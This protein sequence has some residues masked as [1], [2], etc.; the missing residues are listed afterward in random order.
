MIVDRLFLSVVIGVDF[1]EEIHNF[2]NINVWV[3]GSVK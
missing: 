2:N 1:H 3:L